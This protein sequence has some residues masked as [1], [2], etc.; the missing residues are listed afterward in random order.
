MSSKEIEDR[1]MSER[2]P[3]PMPPTP[4]NPALYAALGA[5]AEL[6]SDDPAER[7]QHKVERAA[8]D[9][10]R[11]ERRRD[12]PPAIYVPRRPSEAIRDAFMAYITP[13][14]AVFGSDAK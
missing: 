6:G 2:R 8:N 11:I 10:E 3:Q 1:I 12:L 9:P 5:I 4:G 13:P 14:G 7:W